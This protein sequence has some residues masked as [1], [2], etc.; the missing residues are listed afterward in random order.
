DQVGADVIGDAR[1]ELA[2]RQEGDEVLLETAVIDS[3]VLDITATGSANLASWDFAV[4][5]EVAAPELGPVL[6]A[7][8]IEGAGT[9]DATGRAVSDA[10]VMQLTTT[11]RLS[12]FETGFA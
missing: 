2:V 9:I 8:G 3:E 11:A 4:D 1:I 12:G 6:G 5:F 7:Y 10:G